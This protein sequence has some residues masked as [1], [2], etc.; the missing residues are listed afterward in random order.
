MQTLS[1][2]TSSNKSGYDALAA[3][4]QQVIVN[5]ALV[6]RNPHRVKFSVGLESVSAAEQAELSSAIRESAEQLEE[7]VGE[8]EWNEELSQAQQD[9]GVILLNAASDPQAYHSAATAEVSASDAILDA[10]A[11]DVAN[12]STESYDAREIE[13]TLAR[14]IAFNIGAARQQPALELL[15]PTITVTPDQVGLTLSV[16]RNMVHNHFV[17]NAKGLP[18]AEQFG[19][20]SLIDALIDSGTQVV[21][22]TCR[23]PEDINDFLIEN[24]IRYHSINKN[25]NEMINQW[26]NDPRKAGVDLFIDDKNI[27]CKEI[28]WS[29]IYKE[30]KTQGYII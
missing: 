28:I 12:I 22:W 2:R 24:G 21:I 6:N 4:L 19:N 30:L 29:D 5:E 7:T 13:N 14:S 15:F 27:F 17:H 10:S 25:T 3:K 20:K 16:T 9:A 26:G 11:V 8:T 18:T 23:K 1:S